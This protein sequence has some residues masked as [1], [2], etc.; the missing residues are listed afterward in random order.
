MLSSIVNDMMM[1]EPAIM[2]SS[3]LN[4][5]DLRSPPKY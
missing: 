2:Q 5:S 1:G 4:F 3:K